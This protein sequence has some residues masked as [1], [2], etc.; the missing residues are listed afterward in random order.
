M[1]TANKKRLNQLT[2]LLKTLNRC[3]AL[4]SSDHTS[5]DPAVLQ[6]AQRTLDSI[7]IN[8]RTVEYAIS[9]HNKI[10]A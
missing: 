1:T 2:K 3:K 4:V 8:I 5:N 6:I 7:E 9:V 10:A